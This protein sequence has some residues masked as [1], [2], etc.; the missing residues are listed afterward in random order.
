M[1]AKSADFA[2]T[3]PRRTSPKITTVH[4]QLRQ[5]HQQINNQNYQIQMNTKNVDTLRTNLNETKVENYSL[6]SASLDD[7]LSNNK[8]NCIFEHI[9]T[10]YFDK[11]YYSIF[12]SDCV[13][14]FG[15]VQSSR[16]CF[17]LACVGLLFRR[18]S[19][20]KENTKTTTRFL[21]TYEFCTATAATTARRGDDADDDSPF[22]PRWSPA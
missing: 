10:R 20:T 15:S 6:K 1:S 18:I 19:K 17:H 13:L 21:T 5:A 2:R 7:V 22:L 12:T 14:V 9:K 8:I 4:E 3:P 11:L 16:S